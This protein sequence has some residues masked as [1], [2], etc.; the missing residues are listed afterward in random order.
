[1][2][3][4]SD[5]VPVARY[6]EEELIGFCSINNLVQ[7]TRVRMVAHLKPSAA[8]NVQLLVFVT[9]VLVFLAICL[10]KCRDPRICVL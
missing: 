10:S 6:E 4:S 2:V 1:M 3:V 9:M 8:A 7:T 5:Q